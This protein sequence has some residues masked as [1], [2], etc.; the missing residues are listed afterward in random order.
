[1]NLKYKTKIEA[2]LDVLREAI[3]N[4]DI[5]PG[6][7]IRQDDIAERLGI[8]PTP[9]REALR[10]L[11]AEGLLI[12]VPH[13]GVRVAELSVDD[14]RDI[15]MVRS[16]V[17]GFAAQLAIP[18]LAAEDI[19]QLVELQGLME[20]SLAKGELERLTGVN[21]QWHSLICK[22]ARSRRLQEIITRLWGLFPWD[23]FWVI[24]DRAQHSV[25][26]H[27]RL[28]QAIQ[29]RDAEKAER[30]MRQHIRSAGDSV[31]GYLQ[32]RVPA[33]ALAATQSKKAKP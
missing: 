8:S 26:E 20:Q 10:R 29:R 24:H 32:G 16:L 7:R 11:E 9:V 5:R 17:E 4:G 1:M 30:L 23:T 27:R 25:E 15:Y 6:Q 31:L 12:Y 28:L 14:A 18:N 19:Q 2:V 13:K 33:G 21:D 22:A 3:Q